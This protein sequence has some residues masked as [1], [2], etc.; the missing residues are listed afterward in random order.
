MAEDRHSWRARLTSLVAVIG[1][2]LAIG[3]AATSVQANVSVSQSPQSLEIHSQKRYR[4][5]VFRRTAGG[6]LRVAD[7]SSHESHASH[8][9]H[10]SH[11]SS[12]S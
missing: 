4:K 9:S 11:G 8:S 7:H 12:S 2:S 5:L 1:T 3:A 10:A 6:R